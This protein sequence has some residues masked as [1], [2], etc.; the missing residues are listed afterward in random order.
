MANWE[1]FL[2]IPPITALSVSVSL[3]VYSFLTES[4]LIKQNKII[5]SAITGFVRSILSNVSSYS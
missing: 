1:F 4:T 5:L 3:H 2:W